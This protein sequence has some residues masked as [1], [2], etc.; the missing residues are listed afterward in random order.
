MKLKFI[1]AELAEA[2]KI[3][4]PVVPARSTIPAFSA[5]QFTAEQ[6]EVAVVANNGEQAICTRLSVEGIT[7]DEAPS[8]T[9]LVPAARL[10]AIINAAE[11]EMLTIESTDP[12]TVKIHILGSTFELDTLPPE[13]FPALPSS[14]SEALELDAVQL[15]RALSQVQHA[16]STDDSRAILNGVMLSVGQGHLHAVAT[17]GRRLALATPGTVDDP[18][19]RQVVLPSAAVREICKVIA[20]EDPETALIKINSAIIAIELG[21]TTLFT[22]MVAGNFPNYKQVIPAS[23]THEI[24]INRAALLNK[25]NQVRIIVAADAA[26]AIRMEFSES[27]VALKANAA[28]VGRAE[29]LMQFSAG[30]QMEMALNP[31]FLAQALKATNADEISFH[32]TD[33]LSPIVIKTTDLL[34]VIM[35]VRCG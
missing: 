24:A 17:D 12:E 29:G 32:L 33:A 5:L 8:G 7:G 14:E 34:Q 15:H 6:G 31:G 21:S 16:Q 9:L 27:G 19:A 10:T 26:L 23:S 11:G 3:C 4:G 1:K 18:D 20:I 2:L 28:E 30:F 13:G 25:V 35:P 22:K